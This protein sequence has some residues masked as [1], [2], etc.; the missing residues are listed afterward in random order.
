M[1]IGIWQEHLRD[2]DQHSGYKYSI[3][4]PMPCI[5]CMEDRYPVMEAR[6]LQIY[7]LARKRVVITHDNAELVDDIRETIMFCS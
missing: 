6:A 2:L 5:V 3:Y 7:L 1:I 4:S